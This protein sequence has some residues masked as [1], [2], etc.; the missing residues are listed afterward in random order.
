MSI[1]MATDHPQ[2]LPPLS[3]PSSRPSTSQ[4]SH[5]NFLAGQKRP[6]SF[7][8]EEASPS[9][10]A[11]LPS[12]D[13]NSW[14]YPSLRHDSDQEDAP[15]DPLMGNWGRKTGKGARWIRKGKMA[16]WGPGI[17]DWEAEDHARKRVKLLLPP[18]RRSPSPP[19]LP[20]MRSP[21][22]PLTAPYALPTQQH[23]NYTSFVMD[24]GNTHSFRA[25]ML[26]DL[27]RATS[28]LVEGEATMKRALGRLWQ[29]IS[30][31]P[32]RPPA[33]DKLVP[34]REDED[35]DAADERLA[36]APDLTPPAH[37]HFL[38]SYPSGPPPVF[39]QSQFTHPEVQLETLEK[40]LS[41]LRELQDDGREYVERLEEIREGLG[42]VQA[43]REAVW[44]MVRTNAVKEL[45]SMATGS[46]L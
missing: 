45:Q 7:V 31:D 46:V 22:P 33:D 32:A 38:V 40:C 21:S 27:E 13:S 24:R 2:N 35:E 10:G 8:Y 15:I 4:Q 12:N 5:P 20:H 42:D 16:A 17:E 30:E 6:A 9:F 3:R 34:K 11:T 14:Y 28:G 39:E 29:V 26:E 1:N 44:K 41:A 19:R 43:Q 23:L 25:D 37:K 36:R 18:E